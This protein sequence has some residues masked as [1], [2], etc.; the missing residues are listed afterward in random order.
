MKRAASQGISQ[1]LLAHTDAGLRHHSLA[2]LGMACAQAMSGE[3][4]ARW[5]AAASLERQI[6]Q[7]LVGEAGEMGGTAVWQVGVLAWGCLGGVER[8]TMQMQ[9]GKAGE[10][11]RHSVSCV[12]GG[13]C[14]YMC[15]T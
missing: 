15:C 12:A 4:C 6:L 10:K 14:T 5:E 8:Q 9:V 13:W 7:M 11:V 3:G 1:C 2:A